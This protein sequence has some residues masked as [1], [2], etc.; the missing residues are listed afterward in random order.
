MMIQLNRILAFFG[1]ASICTGL[2]IGIFGCGNSEPPEIPE[3]PMGKM[4]MNENPQEK[5]KPGKKKRKKKNSSAD[6]A[7]IEGTPSP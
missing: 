6:P 7:H 3:P 2:S 5:E 4:P 1:I